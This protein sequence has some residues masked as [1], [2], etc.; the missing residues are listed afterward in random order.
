MAN[1]I[2]LHQVNESAAYVY[3]AIGGSDGQAKG[4]G[5]FKVA[6]AGVSLTK[7]QGRFEHQ[8][9]PTDELRCKVYSHDSTNLEPD[10]VLATSTNTIDPSGYTLETWEF[11]GSLTLEKDTIYWVIFERTGAISPDCWRWAYSPGATQILIDECLI[12]NENTSSWDAHPSGQIYNFKVL[13]ESVS[14]EELVNYD[15]EYDAYYNFAYSTTYWGIT[16]KFKTPSN[17]DGNTYLIDMLGAGFGG[18]SGSNATVYCEIHEGAASSLDLNNTSSTRIGGRSQ[19][20]TLD[21]ET[22]THPTQTQAWVWKTDERPELSPDTEYWILFAPQSVPGGD[23]WRVSQDNTDPKGD[24]YTCYRVQSTGSL[25]STGANEVWTNLFVLGTQ[26]AS[27]GNDIIIPWTIV[28]LDSYPVNRDFV[29]P[30]HM[31]LDVGQDNILKWNIIE[32]WLWEL[33]WD[34]RI[35]VGEDNSLL[36]KILNEAQYDNVLRWNILVEQDNILRW[37]LRPLI[38]NDWILKYS[39]MLEADN[40]LKWGLNV[41]ITNDF[42]LKWVI[43]SQVWQDVALKYHIKVESDH[44]ILIPLRQ[45]IDKDFILKSHFLEDISSDNI[46]RFNIRELNQVDADNKLRWVLQGRPRIYKI[47]FE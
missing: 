41:Q 3:E 15:Y 24:G 26:R 28:D 20:Q 33:V 13:G 22:Y 45:Q 11:D 43:D 8:G 34:L 17:T 29:L 16:A 10:A 23:G 4:A 44:V 30:W 14:I 27:I 18:F 37:V 38:E 1:E 7:V 36:W 40:L 6:I 19:G 12:W 32:E 47:T 31:L 5:P 21:G 35:N 46:L 9:S 25:T 2:T 39:I 42:V